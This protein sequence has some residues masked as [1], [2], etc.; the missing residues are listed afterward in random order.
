MY[1]IERTTFEKI[2]ILKLSKEIP[3]YSKKVLINNKEY[4]FNVPTN[5]D[6]PCISIKIPQSVQIDSFSFI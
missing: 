5:H 3:D 2:S 1:I 6:Y 4:D